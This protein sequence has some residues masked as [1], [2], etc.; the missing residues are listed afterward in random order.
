[1]VSAVT[2]SNGPSRYLHLYLSLWAFLSHLCQNG[3][4]VEGWLNPGDLTASH[5]W[6]CPS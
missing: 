2:A 6:A 5:T 1:M 3:V 4:H